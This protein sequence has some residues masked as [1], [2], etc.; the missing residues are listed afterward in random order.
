MSDTAADDDDDRPNT[1]GAG[2]KS[3]K[4]SLSS[5]RIETIDLFYRQSIVTSSLAYKFCRRPSCRLARS[6]L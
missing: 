2:M 4:R 1:A 6:L 5:I 3:V